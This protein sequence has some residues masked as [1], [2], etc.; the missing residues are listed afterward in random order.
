MQNP[1]HPN[2]PAPAS[3]PSRGGPVTA[4]GRARSSRNSL[5]HGLTAKAVVLDTESQDEFNT[6]LNGFLDRFRPAN[7]LEAELVESMAA[8]RWRLRRLYSIE[9]RLFNSEI[10]LRADDFDKEFTETD[11]TDR[12]ADAFKSL[13]NGGPSLALLIRYETALNRAFD[14]AFKQLTQLQSAS[15]PT[16]PSHTSSF[17]NP[18]HRPLPPPAPATNIPEKEDSPRSPE[19]APSSRMDTDSPKIPEPGAPVLS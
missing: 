18:P 11:D 10:L 5:R 9:S 7:P 2:P 8:S 12:L 16:P 1:T 19:R 6:L 17:R 15:R 3:T 13:A 14:R 4:E